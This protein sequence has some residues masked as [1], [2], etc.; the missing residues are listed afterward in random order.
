MNSITIKALPGSGKRRNIVRGITRS[1]TL[2]FPEAFSKAF[3]KASPKG[4]LL[5][6]SAES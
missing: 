3:P 1:I 6:E 2:S 5:L 4:E